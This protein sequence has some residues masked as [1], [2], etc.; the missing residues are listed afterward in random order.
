[1]EYVFCEVAV[2]LVFKAMPTSPPLT[3][4]LP[5]LNVPVIVRGY[6]LFGTSEREAMALEE[7]ALTAMAM[8]WWVVFVLWATRRGW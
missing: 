7:Q 2:E 3:E 6:A 4:A 8:Y 1:V 5:A